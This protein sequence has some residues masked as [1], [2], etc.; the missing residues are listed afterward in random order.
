MGHA[1][2]FSNIPAP[3]RPKTRNLD[4]CKTKLVR[5]VNHHNDALDL[6]WE[7]ISLWSKCSFSGK[8]Y[9]LYTQPT[10]TSWGCFRSSAP[11]DSYI[12]FVQTSNSARCK[13]EGSLAMCNILTN[14][15]NHTCNRVCTVWLLYLCT[16]MSKIE[17][18]SH[19][20]RNWARPAKQ[21]SAQSR[22]YQ[23]HW[24]WLHVF[25][26][27][28]SVFLWILLK[29]IEYA[30]FHCDGCGLL[31]WESHGWNLAVWPNLAQLGRCSLQLKARALGHTQV[32]EAV[33]VSK[34]AFLG[35]KAFRTVVLPMPMSRI[36]Q[37]GEN[38]HNIYAQHS[39]T[40]NDNDMFSFTV[41][42]SKPLLSRPTTTIRTCHEISKNRTLPRNKLDLS[43]HIT[44]FRNNIVRSR[45]ILNKSGWPSSWIQIHQKAVWKCP[46]GGL[47]HIRARNC[48]CQV[49]KC[50]SCQSVNPWR[51][52]ELQSLCQKSRP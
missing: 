37:R 8:G 29:S 30:C 40:S 44:T 51:L 12:G 25:G 21:A 48:K 7:M 49:Y 34:D 1:R 47:G 4:H 39:T 16:T 19:S 10:K 15:Q 28:P 5:G 23:W 41:L 26:I 9:T 43:D 33:T 36:R 11:K 52:G 42:S 32:T 13:S 3:P 46:Y 31:S 20:H 22:A 17:T 27:P 50:T 14:Q 6:T 35:F 2:Y 18:H 38:M 24:S 45:C